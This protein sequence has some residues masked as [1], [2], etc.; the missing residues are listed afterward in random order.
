M[1]NIPETAARQRSAGYEELSPSGI[2]VTQLLHL[3]LR[4]HCGRVGRKT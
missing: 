4:E 3:W 2:S 1:K